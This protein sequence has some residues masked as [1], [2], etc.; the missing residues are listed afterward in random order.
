MLLFTN[1]AGSPTTV[2]VSAPLLN[3]IW[4]SMMVTGVASC[5]S[6]MLH[7]ICVVFPTTTAPQYCPVALDLSRAGVFSVTGSLALAAFVNVNVVAGLMVGLGLPGGAGGGVPIVVRTPSTTARVP[8]GDVKVVVVLGAMDS[9]GDGGAGGG[10]L[11]GG[12]GGLGPA[13]K[14]GATE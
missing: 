10:G 2:G 13:N 1:T 8:T 12:G 4:P 9:G 7:T 14:A 6:V 5:A 11:G 3:Q